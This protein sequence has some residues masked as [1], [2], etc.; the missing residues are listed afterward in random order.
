MARPHTLL[1]APATRAARLAPLALLLCAALPAA[2]AR[3]TGCDG[4]LWPLA[5]ERAWMTAADSTAVA[6]GAT[7]PV[8]PVDKAIT[9]ALVP[10]A[11]VAFPAAPTSTPKPEDADTLGGVVHFDGFP[12]AGHY[13]VTLSGPGWIDVVQNSAALEA[14]AHTGSKEC[15]DIRKSVRFEIAPGPFAIQVAGVRAREVK[16]A[17]RPAAD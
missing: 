12:E 6:S 15:A 2:T 13:Q 14:T 8:P 3:A 9:L 11:Q 16:I 1:S 10:A 4:F 17:V 7:L 5:T